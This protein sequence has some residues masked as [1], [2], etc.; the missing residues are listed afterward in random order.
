V[1]SS[2][3][4]NLSS[5]DNLSAVWKAYWIT[6]KRKIS[7]GIDGITP[8]QFNDDL[9][10]QLRRLQADIRSDYHYS[11]LRGVPIPKTDSPKM[12]LICIPTVRDRVI[13]R[14]LLRVIEGR[15]AALG[16]EAALSDA[17]SSGEPSPA[18]IA[19]LASVDQEAAERAFA[20]LG[21]SMPAREWRSRL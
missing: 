14:A 21:G 9:T 8:K 1:T 3:L 4:H 20:V 19:A 2:A 15:A 7:C 13:Q 10:N 11:Q 16:V 18:A 17:G 6:A 5:L 12:R